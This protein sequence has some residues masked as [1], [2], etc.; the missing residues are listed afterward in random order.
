MSTKNKEE[1]TPPEMV[2]KEVE[3]PLDL[4]EKSPKELEELQSK[5][6]S[7]K[8]ENHLKEEEKRIKATTC[9]VCNRNL[10]LKPEKYM[11]TGN[12]PEEKECPGCEK[13]LRVFIDYKDNPE[14]STAEISVKS[15]GYVWETKIPGQW[16]EKHV[17]R[18][19]E[20]EM[21]RI[22]ENKSSL[23]IEEQKLFRLVYLGLKKQKIVK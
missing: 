8:I 12:T 4:A 21:S 11:Q 14:T 10:K 3:K 17:K 2:V 20:E 18:W 16:K 22:L 1:E 13:L 15:G 9:P 5:I 6:E 7:Q 23:S 19:A